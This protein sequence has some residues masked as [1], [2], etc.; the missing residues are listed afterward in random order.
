[1]ELVANGGESRILFILQSRRLPH[2]RNEQNL[3][4]NISYFSA[5]LCALITL[6]SLNNRVQEHS[7][8]NKS[9]DNKVIHSRWFFC[10]FDF[11]ISVPFP[12]ANF[13]SL[14]GTNLSVVSGLSSKRQT[15]FLFPQ[16]CAICMLALLSP[17]MNL[18]IISH[19]C[20]C[21]SITVVRAIYLR[22]Q[23]GSRWVRPYL[24][25]R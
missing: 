22:S 18:S 15:R 20:V 6:D 19:L 2:K 23:N 4:R 1:M 7:E 13:L 11:F 21:S 25:H 9:L 17:K 12:K 8:N 5:D 10:L 24:P 3:Q 14:N 16:T